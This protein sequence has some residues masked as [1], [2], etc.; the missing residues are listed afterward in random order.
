LNHSDMLQKLEASSP[1]TVSQHIISFY[2]R[3]TQLK[4]K[5]GIHLSLHGWK[6]DSS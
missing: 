5:F 2:W 1:H 3:F 6:S 4:T